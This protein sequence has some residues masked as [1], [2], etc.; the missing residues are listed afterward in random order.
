MM[1]KTCEVA[2]VTEDRVELGFAFDLYVDTVNKEKNR[3][4]IEGVFEQVLGK[5]IRVKAVHKKPEVEDPTIQNL[6]QEF[7]GSVI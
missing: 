3:T 4:I 5:P 7:G 6:V 1:M 2:G